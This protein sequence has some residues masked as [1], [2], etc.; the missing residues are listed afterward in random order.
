[1]ILA[2]RIKDNPRNIAEKIKMLLLNSELRKDLA[3]KGLINVDRFSWDK[4]A[5]KFNKILE[6][7]NFGNKE[8]HTF[9]PFNSNQLVV[10]SKLDI[11]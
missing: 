9:L 11:L 4:T 1:M 3:E 5:N 10:N 7:L 2:K 6:G 8:S